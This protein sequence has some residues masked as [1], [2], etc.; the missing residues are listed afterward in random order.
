MLKDNT[1]L[2]TILYAIS[3]I[4]ESRVF[5]KIEY[6]Y[7]NKFLNSTKENI[8]MEEREKELID[9]I[10]SKIPE[11]TSK[12]KKRRRGEDETF[13]ANKEIKII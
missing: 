7:L 10:I 1:Y 5:S 13:T 3:N 9:S 8:T 12:N 2:Y 6:D 4:F 11:T